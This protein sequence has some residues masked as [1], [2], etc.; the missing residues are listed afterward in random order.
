MRVLRDCVQTTAG[1][2][3][4]RLHLREHVRASA[5]G[6]LLLRAD[7]RWQLR[8]YAYACANTCTFCGGGPATAY[9]QPLAASPLRLRLREHVHLLRRGPCYC[10]QT[11]AGG[12]PLRLRTYAGGLSLL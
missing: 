8:R 9:G 7:N 1:G 12:S 11:T 4:L 3:P 5:A 6:A 10:V 2:S